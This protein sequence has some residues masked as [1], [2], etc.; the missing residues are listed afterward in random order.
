MN[1]QLLFISLILIV[2]I[3]L[4]KLTGK[5]GIP[6]LLVFI[7]LGMFF[8]SDGVVKIP[9][10]NYELAQQICTLLLMFIMF[11]GGFGTNWKMAKPVFGK[12]IGLS[13]IGVGLTA[14][15]TTGFCYFIMGMALPDSFLMAAVIS[16]TDAA[17]V[18]SILKSKKLNLKYRSASMLEVESGSNDPASY[19]L[20]IMALNIMQGKSQSI[21]LFLVKQIGIGVVSGV[22]IGVAAAMILKQIR[23]GIEGLET[24]FIVAVCIL[25]FNLPE[26][27]GGNGYLAVYITGFIIGNSKFEN[28]I[29]LVHFFDGVTELAQMLI[30]FLLGLLSFPSQIPE[31]ILPS[32]L[33]FL[34]MTFVARP[35]AVFT[36]L[37]PLRAPTN[38]CLFVSWAGLRGAASIVFA[39]IAVVSDAETN[40]DVFHI[41][42]CISLMSVALQGTLLPWVAK[43]LSMI[44][45]NESVMKTFNDYQHEVQIQLIQTSIGPGHRW[46]G[47]RVRE[48]DLKDMLIVLIKRGDN[49]IIPQG[50]TLVELYDILVLTGQVYRDDSNIRLGEI[51]IDEDSPW[52][53]KLL[54]EI[55]LPKET[56]IMVIQRA[57]GSF[58]VPNGDTVI[59]AGDIFIQ[60]NAERM[61]NRQKAVGDKMGSE[62]SEK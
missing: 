4:S 47:R 54:K 6:T 35:V 37:K 50:D 11:Y 55:K 23:F 41:V 24:V 42:F 14:A 48:L 7:A 56:L 21:V 53:G 27:F 58:V 52:V 49:T 38:Q 9:F 19:M 2:C 43:K 8:G 60:N 5:V 30:F 32:I 45:E 13:T 12:A 51:Q 18:F 28:K 40:F 36:I 15:I 10:S 26:L 34:F 17:S 29:S 25:S 57:D 33:I 46:I 3:V 31:I 44:D 20:T 22:L 62:H 61:K 1:G 16:S 59:E 39:I